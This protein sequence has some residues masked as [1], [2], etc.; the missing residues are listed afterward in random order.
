MRFLD[1]LITFLT[2]TPIGL[3]TGARL[4]TEMLTHELGDTKSFIE[5]PNLIWQNKTPFVFQDKKKYMGRFPLDRNLPCSLSLF[6]KHW[7]LAVLGKWLFFLIKGERGFCNTWL[8]MMNIFFVKFFCL[9]WLY[10]NFDECI[11][12]WLNSA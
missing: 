5:S 8:L 6:W 10:L 2:S 3:F 1:E 7:R 9:S 12:L 4:T 11:L